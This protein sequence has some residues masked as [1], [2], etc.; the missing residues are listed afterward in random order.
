MNTDLI[1]R[2]REFMNNEAR[3]CSMDYGCITAEYVFRSWGG[4][5][6]IEEIRAGLKMI[7]LPT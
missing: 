2:L 4:A 6:A 7:D 1:S 5:V 3:S